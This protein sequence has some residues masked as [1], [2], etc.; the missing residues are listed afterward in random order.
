MLTYDGKKVTGKKVILILCICIMF[1][2][3]YVNV[4]EKRSLS[5]F[6]INY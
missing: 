6:K 2:I 3:V 4:I 1:D 5:K